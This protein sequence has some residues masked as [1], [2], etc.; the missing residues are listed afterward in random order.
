MGIQKFLF[1]I[2]GCFVWHFLLSPK[3]KAWGK[4]VQTTTSCNGLLS[5]CNNVILLDLQ[6]RVNFSIPFRSDITNLLYCHTCLV[7]IAKHEKQTSQC[8]REAGNQ[9]Y[10]NGSNFD[11]SWNWN[12]LLEVVVNYIG[13][14][15]LF[16][17]SIPT[18]TMLYY[19][20]KHSVLFLI[21]VV[22][23]LKSIKTKYPCYNQ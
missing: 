7:E 12:R 15:Y 21:D 8:H 11:R 6:A 3:A 17:Q 22:N 5:N 13:I 2:S 19:K 23:I 1:L 14:T 9:E 18:S 16:W 10:P 20:F 4:T